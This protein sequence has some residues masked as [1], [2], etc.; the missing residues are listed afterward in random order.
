MLIIAPVNTLGKQQNLMGRIAAYLVCIS[1]G[2][3]LF[4]K[5]LLEVIS[6]S[7]LVTCAIRAFK[8]AYAM[9][10]AISPFPFVA[11]SCQPPVRPKA[12]FLATLYIRRKADPGVQISKHGARPG[13]LHRD[14]H[15]VAWTAAAGMLWTSCYKPASAELTCSTGARVR[16]KRGTEGGVATQC[17]HAAL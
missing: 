1:I 11:G 15:K 14:L 9:H 12:I 17:R 6:P 16:A 8:S 7:A 10:A 13:D 4:A 2:K 5:A 3:P